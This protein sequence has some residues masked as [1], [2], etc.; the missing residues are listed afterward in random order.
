[1]SETD[2]SGK[3]R[4]NDTVAVSLAFQRLGDFSVVQRGSEE[5]VLRRFM[6]WSPKGF[7]FTKT[8]SRLVCWFLWSGLVVFFSRQG[9]LTNVNNVHVGSFSKLGSRWRP[10]RASHL[11]IRS[12]S[13]HLQYPAI[14]FPLLG[15]CWFTWQWFAWNVKIGSFVMV[16]QRECQRN[17]QVKHFG[18]VLCD[19]RRKYTATSH[20]GTYKWL[21]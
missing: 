6:L 11:F 4:L 1:M 7:R 17:E 13:T 15:V 12:A 18:T 14:W 2:Y 9:L 10:L 19:L 16:N 20:D 21:L 3:A 5:G 8:V